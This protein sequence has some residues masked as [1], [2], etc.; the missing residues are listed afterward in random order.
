[1]GG[2][3]SLSFFLDIFIQS[4]ERFLEESEEQLG[5][6]VARRERDLYCQDNFAISLLVAAIDTEKSTSETVSRAANKYRSDSLVCTHM[7]NCRM[8]RN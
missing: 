2:L 5:K 7:D 6:N 1:M 3:S 4:V 8:R